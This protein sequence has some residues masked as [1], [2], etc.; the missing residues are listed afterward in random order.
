MR[1]IDISITKATI[2]R[3]SIEYKDDLPRVQA[4]INLLAE[5]G[6][7]ISTY[8]LDSEAWNKNQLF[9]VPLS[10]INPIKQILFQIEQ[11]VAEHC[12]NRMKLI[13]DKEVK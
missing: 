13:P 3:V 11:I 1:A 2:S 7:M 10:M 6:E 4:T 9:E 8:S 5:N 12:N